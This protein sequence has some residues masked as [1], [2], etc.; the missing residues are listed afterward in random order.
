MMGKNGF[1]AFCAAAGLGL[2]LAAC[3]G[4]ASK[5]DA[6]SG[7]RELDSTSAPPS[8]SRSVDDL[9]PPKPTGVDGL[10][11]TLD[12][13]NIAFNAPE[14]MV[15]NK[16]G[17]IHLLLSLNQSIDDLA[18]QIEAEGSKQ[19]A[20]IQVSNRMEARLTG[21]SFQIAAVNPETQAVTADAPTEW[22]WEVRPIASGKQMLHLTLT[23]LLTLDGQPAP[24]TIRTFDKAIEVNVTLGQRASDLLS[25]QWEWLWMV[26]IAPMAAWGVSRLRRRSRGEADKPGP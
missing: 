22:K 16:P 11:K 23:A 6:A 19:G 25:S 17:M 1:L 14:S 20:R 15:R 10:L 18:R 4:D 9:E 7:S 3:S 12:W 13:G 5:K 26:L 24:R 8:H 2:L 21:T